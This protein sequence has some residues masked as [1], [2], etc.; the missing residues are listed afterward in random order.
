MG[1]EIVVHGWVPQRALVSAAARARETWDIVSAEW[2]RTLE[3]SFGQ[4]LY[5][6]SAMQLLVEVQQTPDR[7]ETLLVLGH[8]P[9]IEDFARRLAS[10]DS[11]PGA[12]KL[13][14]DKFPT[15]A[16]AR[17]EFEAKWEELTFG[18]ARLTDCLRPKDL[19]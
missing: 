19:D 13:L 5:H 12:L 6:A 8:N 4:T 17:F 1:R 10:D 3:A 18:L 15:A 16:L 7:I 11:D 9:E 14:R 2:P